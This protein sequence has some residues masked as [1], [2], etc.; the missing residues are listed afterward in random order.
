FVSIV[1]SCENHRGI[2]KSDKLILNLTRFK[3]SWLILQARSLLT[4]CSVF[5]DQTFSLF[6]VAV[7]Q[8]RLK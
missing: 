4:R 1:R 5:K 7:F 3:I 2:E 8:R 6:I